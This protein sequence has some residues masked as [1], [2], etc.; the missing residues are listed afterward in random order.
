MCSGFLY[1]ATNVLVGH[2]TDTIKTKMQA[3]AEHYKAESSMLKTVANVYRNEGGIMGFYR[4]ALPPFFGSMFYR[5][6]QFAIAEAFY[7]Y[8]EGNAFMSTELGAGV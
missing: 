6:S 5:S 2:P 7:T 4:G 3:Q 1:G 8:F